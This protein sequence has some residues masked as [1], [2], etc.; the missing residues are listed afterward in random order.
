MKGTFSRQLEM[1]VLFAIMPLLLMVGGWTQACFPLLWLAGL[2]CLYLMARD[3][4]FDRRTKWPSVPFRRY[5]VPMLGCFAIFALLITASLFVSSPS[6]LFSFMKEQPRFWALLMVA[7]PVE[8]VLPQSLVYRAFFFYRYRSL[9]SDGWPMML[10]SACAFAFA[11]IVYQN[12]LALLFTFVGGLLFARTYRLT[13]SLW[14]S[15]LEHSLYGCFIFTIGL[16][17][18]FSLGDLW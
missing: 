2:V 14:L 3:H 16:G 11:H 18:F 10:A 13:H 9:F 8:S 5:L 7:Y 4:V 6:R 12:G 1:L 17:E 15:T